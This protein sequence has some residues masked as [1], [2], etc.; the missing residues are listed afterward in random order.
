[1]Q[2]LFIRDLELHTAVDDIVFK[3]VQGD[4]LLVAVT[5]TEILLCDCPES[6]SVRYGMYA[7]V[8]GRFRACHGK[9]RDLDRRHDGVSAGF[10]LVD[11]RTVAADFNHIPAE[12]LHPAGNGFAIVIGAASDSHKVADFDC[13]RGLSGTSVGLPCGLVIKS[14]RIALNCFF[15]SIA[16]IA[17]IPRIL[18]S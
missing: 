5:V 7:I 6:I 1:M 11:Y 2:R 3:S 10:V 12:L 14:P 13:R 15:P 4:D 9:C 17:V 16:V 18:C 8:L